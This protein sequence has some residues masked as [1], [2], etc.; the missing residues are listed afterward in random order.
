MINK[1]SAGEKMAISS[2]GMCLDE[3]FEENGL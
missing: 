3:G 2:C 1:S